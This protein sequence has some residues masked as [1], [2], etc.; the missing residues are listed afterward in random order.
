MSRSGYSD[1]CENLNLWRANV[2]RTIAG[3]RGQAFFRELITAMEAMPEKRLIAHDL[4]TDNGDVCAL[5]SLGLKRGLDMGE[6]DPED[7][8][9]IGRAFRISSMLA[10]EVVYMN[11]EYGPS[12]RETPEERW[13]RIRAW[14]KDQLKSEVQS[15]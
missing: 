3:K 7:P 10:Q 15:A 12:Y 14:A 6:L 11:D 1:D 13:S 9:Q 5:G 2:D 4:R 8:D